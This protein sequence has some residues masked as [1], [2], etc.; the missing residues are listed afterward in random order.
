MATFFFAALV[1]KATPQGVFGEIAGDAEPVF[2]QP[3]AQIE[4]PKEG[5]RA[6]ESSRASVRGARPRRVR[7]FRSR[8]RHG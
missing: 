2:S 4:G 6:P 7:R 8:D 1:M 5:S 3:P